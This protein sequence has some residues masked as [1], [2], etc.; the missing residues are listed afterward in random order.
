MNLKYCIFL[1]PTLMVVSLSRAQVPTEGV[2]PVATKSRVFISAENSRV[3][4]VGTHVGDD[5]KPRLGGFKDFRGFAEVDPDAGKLVSLELTFAI[6]SIWT[7]FDDLT[8]HLMKADFFN[9]A[10]YPEAVFQST[11]ITELQKGRCNIKGNLTLHGQTSEIML[12]ANFQLNEQGLTLTSQFIVDRTQYGMDQGLDGVQK[13]V[14]ISFTVGVPDKNFLT[15]KGD[16]PQPQPVSL[17]KCFVIGSD[18]SSV[19]FVGTHVGNDPK[20]RLG[21]FKNFKGLVLMDAKGGS[22]ESI[23]IDFEIGSIWTEFEKLTGHLMAADFFEQEKFPL[24]KFRSSKITPNGE[25]QYLVNGDLTLHGTTAEL[26]F[27]ASVKAE[28]GGI[29][30][31]SEF[32]LDRTAFGM[33]KMIDGVE[34]E[35]SIRFIIGKPDRQVQKKADEAAKEQSSKLKNASTVKVS[36]PK[37]LQ[38]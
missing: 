34:K 28:N 6:G 31:S 26:S 18:N 29:V 36:L 2:S 27:P 17:R 25:G 30:L 21:G 23:A 16:S 9:Q 22:L 35:V 14:S 4:F 24:A 11:Q 19:E 1:I 13:E 32:N 7:E 5:P 3:E 38:Y 37:M 10:E 12:P 8:K 33:D 20:P 15:E